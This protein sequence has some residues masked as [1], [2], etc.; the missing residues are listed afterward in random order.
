MEKTTYKQPVEKGQILE[1]TIPDIEH[2]INAV[3]LDVIEC[4]TGNDSVHYNCIMYAQKMLF[5]VSLEDKLSIE[6]IYDDNLNIIEKTESHYYSNLKYE[7]TIVGYCEIPVI[8]S[9]I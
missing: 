5:R 6:N 8:P 9:D 4:S 3:V 7:E 2:P 1:I